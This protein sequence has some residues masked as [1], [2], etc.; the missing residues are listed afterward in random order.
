MASFSLSGSITAASLNPQLTTLTLALRNNTY[1][2]F[3]LPPPVIDRPEAPLLQTKHKLYSSPVVNEDTTGGLLLAKPLNETSLCFA[4]LKNATRDLLIVNATT[5]STEID[6]IKTISF[7]D[8]IYDIACNSIVFVVS[9]L[10]GSILVF[11]IGRLKLIKEFPFPGRRH[12]ETTPVSISSSYL[13]L[14]AAESGAGAVQFIQFKRSPEGTADNSVEHKIVNQIRQAHSSSIKLLKLSKS[15]RILLSTSVSGTVIRL[16]HVPSGEIYTHCAGGLS[17]GS[18][19]R[20]GIV[21]LGIH[22]QEE[23][24]TDFIKVVGNSTNGTIHIWAINNG[25]GAAQK[26]EN[27]TAT[28]KKNEDGVLKS[29]VKIRRNTVEPNRTV[30]SVVDFVD[31]LHIIGVSNEG[32]VRQYRLNESLSS[33]RDWKLL[34]HDDFELLL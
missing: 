32:V 16:W 7:N 14:P 34:R 20:G 5:E 27:D 26:S 10:G 17:R 9:L 33:E 4:V 22:E 30:A 2:T 29:V 12:S 11:D 15:G 8:A 25:S 3:R 18:F 28:Q 6:V 21:S 24:S 31:S 1:Q 19:G 23:G 13:A